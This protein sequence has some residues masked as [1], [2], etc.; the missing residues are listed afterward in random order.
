MTRVLDRNGALIGTLGSPERR[1]VVP[2]SQ[3]PKEFLDAV[4]AAEDP[5]FYKHE[6]IDYWGIFRAQVMNVLGGRIGPG[7]WGQGGSTITQKVVQ[8]L[9]LSPEKNARRKL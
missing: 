7:R 9:L 3:I 1:R 8:V 6:G 4:I 5:S 2:L